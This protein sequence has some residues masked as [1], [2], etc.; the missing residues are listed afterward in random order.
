MATGQVGTL[1][2]YIRNLSVNQ[3]T[4]EQTD[5][6]LLRAFLIH[7]D[8]AAFEALVRRHGPMVLRVCLRILRNTHDAEDALQATFLVLARRATS[9]RKRESLASWLHGVAHRMATSA[10]RAAARR[11]RRESQANLT[12]PCDAALS[13]A[14]QELHLLV[15]EEIGRLPDSL[16]EPFVCCCLE[17][18]SC[19]TAHVSLVSR[20]VRCGIVWAGHASYFKSGSPVA[21]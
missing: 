7:T 8:Q 21:V 16:R 6:A 5:G 1:L 2:R 15:D 9:I 4:S 11:H 14:L 10:R 18:K 19:A 17:N 20:K 13:A 12:E 3:K